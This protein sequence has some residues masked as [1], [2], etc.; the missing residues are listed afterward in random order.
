MMKKGLIF[1]GGAGTG[2]SRTAREVRRYYGDSAAYLDGRQFNP[3]GYEFYFS[4]CSPQTKVVII[5]EIV[6]VDYLMRF[7]VAISEG[8]IPV[9]AQGKKPFEIEIEKLIII[10]SWDIKKEDLPTGAS[11][12]RRFTVI[13]FPNVEAQFLIDAITDNSNQ[14]TGASF[15]L[16]E[17]ISKRKA[18]F[19]DGLSFLHTV[20]ETDR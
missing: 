20:S 10:C 17:E 1:I 12:N 9:H 11:F 18:V 13:E 5:D 15:V 2:K 6:E 7:F 16:M 4:S 3:K 14:N 8:K 19:L